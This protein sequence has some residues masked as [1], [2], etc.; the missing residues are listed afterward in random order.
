MMM[1]HKVTE[2]YGV[3]VLDNTAPT[4]RLE[5]CLF[6]YR[7]E[8]NLPPFKMG[9]PIFYK[10]S[11]KYAKSASQMRQETAVRVNECS[12]NA[13]DRRVTSVARTDARGRVI[14][15]DRDCESIVLA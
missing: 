12:R 7:A 15:E 9:K 13:K 4:N 2:N 14:K 5:D 11:Q 1:R 8:V 6:W 10:L 3:L